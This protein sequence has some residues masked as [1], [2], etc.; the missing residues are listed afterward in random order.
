MRSD[1]A[2]SRGSASSQTR[3]LGRPVSVSVEARRSSSA[4]WR[5]ISSTSRS[6]VKQ[7]TAAITVQT[8][9][10]RSSARAVAVPRATIGAGQRQRD[11]ARAATTI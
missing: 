10:R 5:R 1:R 7:T 9:A 6:T 4:D 3:R 2:S 8:I 11:A